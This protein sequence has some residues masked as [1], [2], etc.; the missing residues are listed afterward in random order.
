[1]GNKSDP[2]RII[3][4]DEHDSVRQGIRKLLTFQPGFHVLGE[5][6]D[7]SEAITLAS[8]LT[9]NVLLLGVGRCQGT[10]VYAFDQTKTRLLSIPTVAMIPSGEPPEVLKAFR[11]G[12]RGIILKTSVPRVLLESIRSVAN[13]DYWFENGC[14][15]IL[16]DT[17]RE[18]LPNGNHKTDVSVDHGLTPRELDVVAKVA[19]GRSNKEI[20]QEFSISE[21]TVKHHLTNIFL[22]LGVSSRLEL[23]MFVVNHDVMK[24]QAS[25]VVRRF[26]Q[27]A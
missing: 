7:A 17:L 13:G 19:N 3:I 14:V 18:F 24:S 21:R 27:N 11:L 4:A 16:M 9:P 26:S 12:A 8:R 25:S 2:I 15:K 5:A 23:A 22:K 10:G 6:R 1:M 20:G